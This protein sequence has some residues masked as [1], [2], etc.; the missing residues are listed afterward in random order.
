MH[1]TRSAVDSLGKRL[2]A[3]TASPED[4]ASLDE[5]IRA[6]GDSALPSFSWIKQN[7][8]H[9]DFTTREKTRASIIAKLS[10]GT[11]LSRMQDLWGCR[12]VL[13]TMKHFEMAYDE[14][15]AEFS[16][17]R[18]Y[19]RLG[20]KGY[21]AVHLVSQSGDRYFEIQMRTR[22]QHAWAELSEK[23]AD[24]F[25]FELK[26]GGG[27]MDKRD[28]LLKLS[29]EIKKFEDLEIDAQ[30]AFV[31]DPDWDTD[32]DAL[33]GSPGLR[34]E[35]AKIISLINEALRFVS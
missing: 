34:S 10:R 9:L 21:R 35:R 7:I 18:I 17:A 3:G 12:I 23:M 4:F 11:E 27:P 28:Y 1:L 13:P 14:L 33:E 24:R 2:R 25:G 31:N 20:S 22:V 16:A 32:P 26:H 8:S 6:T 19:D 30:M 29:D 15:Y 5:L